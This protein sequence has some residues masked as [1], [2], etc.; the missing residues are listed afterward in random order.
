VITLQLLSVD[1]AARKA[2]FSVPERGAV[3]AI[4][5]T[6]EQT[7]EFGGRDGEVFEV[8]RVEEKAVAV[9][10]TEALYVGERETSST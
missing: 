7:A 5:L 4:P 6:R 3:I 2:W 1:R 9:E 10:G 8:R